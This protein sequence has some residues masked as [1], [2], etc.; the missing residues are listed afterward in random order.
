MERVIVYK[1]LLFW[2]TN[3]YTTVYIYI[4]KGSTVSRFSGQ[5]TPRWLDRALVNCAIYHRIHSIVIPG[6]RTDSYFWR[7]VGISC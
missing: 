7:H 5:H 2:C 4:L 3:M 6:L 1:A